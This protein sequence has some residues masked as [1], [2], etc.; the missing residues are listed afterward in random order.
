MGLGDLLTRSIRPPSPETPNDNDPASVPPGDRRAALGAAGRPSRRRVRPTE[1]ATTG[2]PPRIIPE[3]L[4]GLARRLVD[5]AWGGGNLSALADTAWACLDL[6][7]RTLATMPPYLVGAAPIARRRLAP[8]PASGHVR[9]LGASS[10]SSCSA[11]TSS[12]EAFVYA[13]A[14]YAHGLPGP[15]PR[16]AAV[17]GPGRHGRRLPPLPGRAAS[18]TPADVCHLRYSGLGR[19][20]PRARPARGRPSLRSSPPKS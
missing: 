16:L 19:R 13:T 6:N 9:E 10:R 2:P 1:P 11:T 3:R 4:V 8:Q 17:D 15:L 20:R 12:G 7:S 18:S 14:R 5:A